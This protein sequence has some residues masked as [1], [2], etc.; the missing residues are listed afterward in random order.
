[1]QVNT[2]LFMGTPNIAIPTLEGTIAA[3]PHARLS[4]MTK[5]DAEKGRGRQL[6]PSPIKKWALDH[7]ESPQI[8]TPHTK[9]ELADTV[10]QIKPDLIII[11]A[12]GMIIPKSITDNYL[13]INC[14]AS[15]L[16]AYRGP[17]PIHAALL[18]GDQTTGI[19]LMQINE[20]MDEGDIL[21][22]NEIPINAE[23]NLSSLSE[24]LGRLSGETIRDYICD[25]VLQD[26]IRRTVQN[27][28]NATFTKLLHTSDR[29]ITAEDTPISAFNKIRTY[30][31][32][33][34]AFI[35]LKDNKII[36]ILN[37]AVENNQL[38]LITVQPEG[39]A[40]MSYHDY[41]LGNPQGIPLPTQG[42]AS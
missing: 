17:S 14:H 42:D 7:L 32:K 35:T 15:I 27:H 2:V 9:T 1:M 34:G 31:P 33:P 8:Y 25:V 6:S 10:N 28:Q 4:I 30:G 22:I 13:C 18:N 3:L 21:H 39:K 38:I 36:K 12:F 19:T 29:E 16:P 37:A 26:K 41:C 5:P 11:I 40:A 20:K 23:D 24:K